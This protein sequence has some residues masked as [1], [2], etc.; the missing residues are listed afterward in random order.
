MST[1]V[2]RARGLDRE[3]I[4]TDRVRWN[5]S[6]A[7]LY[8]E[9]VRRQAGLIAAEGPLACRTGQHTG[10]SP[11]DKFIVREPS[12][13]KEV[14]WGG[15]NRPMRV[16]HFATLHRDLLASLT[17]SELFVQDCYAGADP[18][19]R[20]PIRVITEYAWHSLFARNLFIVDPSAAAEHVAA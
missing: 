1:E 12:S 2:D 3:G 19:Y 9:A 20:L 5:L 13:E 7:A 15:P 4:Q 11:N 8:E 10:R 6:P 17:G 16:Q 18:R 14:A